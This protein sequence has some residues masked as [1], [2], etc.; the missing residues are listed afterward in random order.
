MC[1]LPLGLFGYLLPK[2]AAVKE[3]AWQDSQRG[4]T[5]PQTVAAAATWR[6]AARVRDQ[7]TATTMLQHC[8][9]QNPLPKNKKKN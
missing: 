5:Q 9:P 3:G 1:L 7:A 2:T 8:V 6:Q 4:P